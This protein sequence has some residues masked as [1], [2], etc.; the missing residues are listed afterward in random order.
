MENPWNPN[1]QNDFPWLSQLTCL[2]T[3]GQLLFLQFPTAACIWTA[4]KDMSRKGVVLFDFTIGSRG[5]A[6]T[7]A[8]CEQVQE[9]SIFDILWQASRPAEL[10]YSKNQG[11]SLISPSNYTQL[12]YAKDWRITTVPILKF[13][14]SHHAKRHSSSK[15]S[16]GIG[17]QYFPRFRPQR[18]S[19]HLDWT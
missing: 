18:H 19:D 17:H 4:Q 2:I 11:F 3:A 1:T 13:Q 10:N 8:R 12:L 5:V 6:E 9:S 16:A 14:P 7:A 15:D